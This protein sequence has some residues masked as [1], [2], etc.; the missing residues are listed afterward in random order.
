MLVERSFCSKEEVDIFQQA[1]YWFLLN[2][3]M[4]K[5]ERKKVEFMWSST[6]NTPR[7]V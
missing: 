4:D 1:G 5:F 7:D 3:I 6:A 2:K